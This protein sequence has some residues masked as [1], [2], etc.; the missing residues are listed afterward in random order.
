MK[1]KGNYCCNCNQNTVIL[2]FLVILLLILLYSRKYVVEKFQE[3]QNQGQSNNTSK[4]SNGSTVSDNFFIEVKADENDVQ[5]LWSHKFPSGKV[6][7][8]WT[9]KPNLDT[10][11]FPLG[12][13]IT[14]SDTETDLPP[15]KDKQAL[16]L[17]VSGGQH[18]TGYRRIWNSREMNPQPNVD[19]TVCQPIPPTGYI[20]M[21]DIIT[22]NFEEQ[23]PLNSI[24]CVP[25]GCLTSSG[26]IKNRIFS[27]NPN[28]KPKVSFWNV[29]N[30]GYFFAN[31][32][33]QK[34]ENRKVDTYNIKTECMGR[35]ALAD[36]TENPIR[37]KLFG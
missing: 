6:V 37:V 29:T 33:N 28:N 30:H 7:T 22:T 32:S 23:P 18:P 12:H 31:N 1:N 2:I 17:L 4:Q 26:V 10:Q 24:M 9:C 5:K 27:F 14:L 3:F 35:M 36:E 34:P 13:V 11:F 25:R 15:I 16:T 21:G 19:I 8:F 20:A